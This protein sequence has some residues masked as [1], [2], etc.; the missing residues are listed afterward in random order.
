M[1]RIILCS[2]LFL[3][4]FYE[5]SSQPNL[6]NANVPQE[7][8]VFLTDDNPA[9]PIEYGYVD[10]RDMLWS[11]TIWETI[12]LN[13]RVNFPLYFPKINN[14]FLSADRRSLFRNLMDGIN[15]GKIVEVY[16][17]GYFK[18]KLTMEEIQQQ[19]YASIVNDE[20]KSICNSQGIGPAEC[21]NYIR[22]NIEIIQNDNPGSI[23]T[24]F[25][26]EAKLESEG[27]TQFFVKGTWYF[28]KR[29]GELK[30]RL[31]GIAPAAINPLLQ[32]QKNISDDDK[33][34]QP[35][36]WIWFPNSREKLSNSFVF[37]PRNSSQRISFDHLLNSRRFNAVIYREENVYE[38]RNINEYIQKD[39]LRQ[40][41]ES[42]RIK[43]VIRDFEQDMWS[44]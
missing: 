20:G 11:K 27:I 22:N 23:V 17:D 6:L 15:E 21:E 16:A 7:V 44:N 25:I 3:L 41:L 2:F 43:S 31:L 37:N 26:D 8:G 34:I 40:L 19:L 33:T 39:A 36:F 9:K 29:L 24:D 35:L 38:D 5:L 18:K 28:D 14:G 4:S 1:I 12:D 30:Y 32:L 10:D 42:E 13:E